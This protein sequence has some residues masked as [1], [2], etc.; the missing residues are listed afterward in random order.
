MTKKQTVSVFYYWVMIFDHR[1]IRTIYLFV[2]TNISPFHRN[3]WM[4]F[5]I[6]HVF[7]HDSFCFPTQLRIRNISFLIQKHYTNSIHSST[8][9]FS[10]I[11]MFLIKMSMC[12]CIKFDS[13]TSLFF[14]FRASSRFKKLLCLRTAKHAWRLNTW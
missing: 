13:F 5:K 10:L 11:I 6:Y 3:I 2:S 1:S 12:L 8:H 7:V 14:T 4:L 9:Q